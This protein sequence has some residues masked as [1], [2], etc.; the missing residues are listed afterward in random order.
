MISIIYTE[1]RAKPTSKGAV[2]RAQI[3]KNAWKIYRTVVRISFLTVR[4]CVR[5]NVAGLSLKQKQ[6]VAETPL[7]IRYPLCGDE[8]KD[9]TWADPMSFEN[10]ERETQGVHMANGP[11]KEIASINPYIITRAEREPRDEPTDKEEL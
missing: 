2:T 3:M 1:T 5:R 7:N 10:I 6:A 9:R 11:K 4:K 8:E